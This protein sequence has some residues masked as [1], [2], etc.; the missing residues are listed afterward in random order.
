MFL[1]TFTAYLFIRTVHKIQEC[2]T[3]RWKFFPYLLKCTLTIG[4]Y[5][6]INWKQSGECVR[7]CIVPVPLPRFCFQPQTKR[8]GEKKK[9]RKKEGCNFVRPLWQSVATTAPT[10]VME[11]DDVLEYYG[12]WSAEKLPISVGTPPTLRQSS[13]YFAGVEVIL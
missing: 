3:K 6:N 11:P 7:I 10:R 13:T 9:N 4:L 1:N 8:K 2:K 12:A 5:R